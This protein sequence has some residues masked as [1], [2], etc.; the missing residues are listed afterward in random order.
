[1]S[2]FDALHYGSI[3]DGT[4]RD[5][6]DRPRLEVV[7]PYDGSAVGSIAIATD[8]DVRDA[9]TA[10]ER[11][12]YGTMRRMPAH[13]RADILYRTAE[14]LAADADDL[15][16]LLAL[17]AGKPL[18]EGR[19][20]IARGVQVLKFAA[21]GAKQLYG[22]LIPM[23]SALGGER[24]LGMAQRVPI[25]VVAAIT[26]FNFPL[27]L[28]LHKV[29][30]ALAAGNAVVLKPAEKTPLTAVWLYR[31]LA[32][33]GLP[34]DALHVLMGP[35][36][37]IGN[38][39]CADPRIGKITFTGS[40]AVGWGIKEKARRA[41]VTLELGSNAPNLVFADADLDAAVAS[42]TRGAFANAGQT[43][44]SVQRVYVQEP[45]YE[46]VARRMSE[47]A[48]RLVAG[49]PLDPATD[50]GPM[51]THAAAKRAEDWVRDAVAQGARLLT[52]GTRCGT[53]LAP[54]VI[55]GADSRMKVVCAEAFAPFVCLIPF[56]TE[57]EAI[58]SAND[59]PYGLQAGVFTRDLNRA[60]R[61]AE[62]LET[63]GVWI[64]E[65]SLLRYDH[66]PYGG[67]KLSGTG[68]EGV[69]YALEEMTTRKFI[70]IKLQ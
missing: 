64:N 68:K 15:A 46:E 44:V 8:E 67:V 56:A 35:G 21:E 26:P 63:G 4:M 41:N 18:R 10:A 57:E 34:S 27:N 2:R 13:R 69:K 54:T 20:E 12:F 50:V 33:A 55:A 22:E 58:A 23:D 3:I 6:G 52:G 51:I 14:L 65:A 19:A 30:P 59:S 36:E 9:I 62:A 53:L 42:L 5:K 66:M 17:E 28:V 32:Q 16:K 11:G 38:I 37:P 29:A 1:M 61:V 40:A 24:Q 47:A 70:G 39:L 43:C 48:S 25:G 45:V 31:L 60:L 7:N 49:D